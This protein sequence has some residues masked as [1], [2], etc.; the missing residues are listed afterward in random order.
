[1]TNEVVL[2][3]LDAKDDFAGSLAQLYFLVPGILLERRSGR[4][5]AAEGFWQL[6]ASGS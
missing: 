3:G 1:M 2:A 6:K 5:L 4:L